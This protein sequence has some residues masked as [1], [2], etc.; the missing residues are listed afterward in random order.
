MYQAV[1]IYTHA[2]TGVGKLAAEIQAQCERKKVKVQTVAAK[3]ARMPDLA[4]ADLIFIGSDSQGRTPLHEDFTELNRSLAGVNLA[5][6][7]AGVFTAADQRSLEALREALTDS[8]IDLSVAFPF[9]EDGDVSRA[10]LTHWLEALLK[11]LEE[12]RRDA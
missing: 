1:I 3:E 2:Q 4:A 10:A 11:R 8:G 5:T 12:K 6:R 9:S 7:V